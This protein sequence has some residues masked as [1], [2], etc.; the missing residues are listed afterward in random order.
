MQLSWPSNRC[1]F[2]SSLQCLFKCNQL[3][4]YLLSKDVYNTLALDDETR[5]DL[6]K[7]LKP[8]RIEYEKT[9]VLYDAL[10][11]KERELKKKGQRLLKE[12]SKQLGELVA[13]RAKLYK[14]FSHMCNKFI[15]SSYVKFLNEAQLAT[16]GYVKLLNMAQISTT[17]KTKQ[18]IPTWHIKG[19]RTRF[20]FGKYIPQ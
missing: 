6:E 1:W 19:R 15:L 14:E 3:T 9:Q 17:S 11:A 2:N 13:K 16:S 8:G 5:K 10:I 20:T 12:E 4:E 7:K 18:N